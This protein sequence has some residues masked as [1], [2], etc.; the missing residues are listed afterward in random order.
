VHVFGGWPLPT[1]QMGYDAT[2]TFSLLLANPREL[3][4]LK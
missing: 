1:G 3:A 2:G 4:E